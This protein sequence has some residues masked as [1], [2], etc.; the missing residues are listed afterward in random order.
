MGHFGGPSMSTSKD[1]EYKLAQSGDA[2][3]NGLDSAEVNYYQI[4]LIY[5]IF[6]T[7]SLLHSLGGLTHYVATQTACHRTL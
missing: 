1:A 4:I 7:F 6:K 3:C 5:K 2:T